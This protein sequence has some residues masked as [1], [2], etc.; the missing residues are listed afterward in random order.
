MRCVF[1]KGLLAVLMLAAVPAAAAPQEPTAA[2]GQ[3]SS[4]PSSQAAP[5]EGQAAPTFAPAAP[6][7]GTAPTGAAPNQQPA[8]T[9]TPEP[10]APQTSQPAPAQTPQTPRPATSQAPQ[11]SRLPPEGSPPLVRYVQIA[12]P[13]QGD[14]SLI[15]PATYL[16]YIQTRPSRA[17]DGV[18]V[19][20]HEQTVL[21]DFKRLWA[22]NFLEDLWIEVKDVPYENGVMGKH[23]I[24]N[25]EERQRIKIIDYTGSKKVD[26][27]KIE[28]VMKEENVVLRH[29]TFVDKGTIARVENIARR[30]LAEQGYLD[31]KVTHQIKE[32]PGGPKLVHLSFV[33]DEGPRVRIKKIEFDGNKRVSDGKLR[34]Q[35]KENK[36]KGFLFF[37]GD[38][39]YKETKYEEDAQR[40]EEYYR[41]K[42][43]VTARVGQPQIE[44]LGA[45]SDGKTRYIALKIPV[46]EGERY[47]VGDFEFDGVQTVR[48]DALRSRFKL[49][50]GDWYSEKKIRK[51]LEAAREIYGSVGYW[52]FTGYPDLRPRDLPDPEVATNGSPE[53]P[54]DTPEK[55]IRAP[56]GAPYVDITMRMKEGERYFVNRITFAGNTTTRDN[57][58]RREMRLVE[59]GVF[60]TEALKHSVRRINQLGYFQS[61]EEDPDAVKVEKTPGEKNMVD[62]TLNV[63]EQNR[64]QITF[65][66]GMS[67]F[68]GFFGQLSFQ[69]S[70]F[71]GRGESA[72]FAVLAGRRA[73]NYQLAFTEPFMFDRPIS[74][75]IDLYNRELQ[76]LFAYTQ[77]S[78]GGNISVGFPVADF[79]RAFV[80]YSLAQISVTDVNP[81][82][83]DP[84]VI[85]RNPFLQD[86]LLQGA[87]GRRTISQITPSLIHNTIDNPIFPTQG[88]R[89]QA[90]V[91]IAGLGGNV[92][93]IKPSVE[94]VYMWRHTNRTSLAVRGLWEFI[95]PWGSTVAT[96][97]PN[98]PTKHA[99]PIFERLFLGGEYSVRG[100]DIRSIGPRDVGTP[101]EPGT[102]VV[103][104]GNKSLLFNAE[105]LITIAGPVRLVLFYDA[106]QVRDFGESYAMDAFK[107]STGAEIRFFMPVLNVPFRLIF[108]ANP[109]RAGVLEQNLRE[110]ARKF[111]FKFA[112]GSTF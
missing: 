60:N 93:F 51:G 92:N 9:Q 43:Y 36:E 5:A 110:P 19:P 54:S 87:G 103:I 74:A 89:F 33:I 104:G 109:Q 68:E 88:Q 44:N 6:D 13:N 24:F 22:T 27:S 85:G 20:Y 66:A 38:G 111:V 77:R 7:S 97:D 65:G 64:N 3:E 50:H 67:Q 30:L 31:A 16:Y 4:E 63:K 112:V 46:H 75:G 105:Y 25:L 48:E 84:R 11:P 90:T 76:Y 94:G 26:Q 69:T 91:D 95:Q 99:L 8:T 86:A 49:D 17:S 42:G 81:I 39:I 35:M 1:W 52:E 21:D 59:Q 62:V 56:D 107:T 15:D 78:R 32:L 37:G 96:P 106:G 10:A 98:D 14:V 55:P 58:I 47:R 108:A 34:R 57:V 70:N 2:A 41:N 23:I 82:F 73:K 45:S 29:D 18:W 72:T 53:P 102:F 79:T 71:L 83:N 40:V 80:S 12:F 61:L 100:F 101:E 28:E